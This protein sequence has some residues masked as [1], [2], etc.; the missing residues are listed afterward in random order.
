MSDARKGALPRK[1]NVATND[2][3]PIISKQAVD[4]APG[5]DMIIGCPSRDTLCLRKHHAYLSESR[6]DAG[7]IVLKDHRQAF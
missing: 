4:S 6:P 5:I 7:D 1:C 2:A 3:C